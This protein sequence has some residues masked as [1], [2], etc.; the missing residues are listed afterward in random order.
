MYRFVPI[1]VIANAIKHRFS[2]QA[3]RIGIEAFGQRNRRETAALAA[4][5]LESVRGFDISTEHLEFLFDQYL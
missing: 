1:F 2:T 5:L 3:S 4:R